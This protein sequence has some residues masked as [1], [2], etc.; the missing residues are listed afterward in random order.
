M[1][2]I[3]VVNSNGNIDKL[4][5]RRHLHDILYLRICSVNPYNPPNEVSLL[6]PTL[7]MKKLRLQE[8]KHL[9]QFTHLESGRSKI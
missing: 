1:N 9:A 4:E 7:Q 8:I 5:L 3:P 6:P 2:I